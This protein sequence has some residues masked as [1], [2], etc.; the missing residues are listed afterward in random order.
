M[1]IKLLGKLSL[2]K[3]VKTGEGQRKTEKERVEERREEVLA[4]GRKFKY[5]LQYAKHKMVVNTIIVALVAVVA[6]GLTGFLELYKFQDM[7][8]IMYRISRILPLPVAEVDGEKVKFADYLMTARS[9]IAALEQQSGLED[10]SEDK[11]TM[12]EV[13]KRTALTQAEDLTY[14]VK[15]AKEEEIE[16]SNEEVAKAFDEHRKVGGAERSEES[17]LKVLATNFGLSKREYQRMLYL[18]LL[19]AKVEQ[20]IDTEALK[21]AEALERELSENGGDFQAAKEKFGERVEL[22]GTSGLIDNKNVDGGRS[23]KAASLEEGA[24]SG[25]FVSSNGDG[26]YFVKLNKKTETQVDYVSLFVKFKEFD[27]RL[28]MIRESGGVKEYIKLKETQEE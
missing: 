5:P 3:A 18:A 7:G 14:A 21:T 20:K 10:N 11:E 23:G 27:K 22:E 24:Q 19:R 12:I 26:Y 28:E 13:Y 4:R 2:K 8:D 16:V 6:L 25:K 15:L 9:S 17:F 1:K